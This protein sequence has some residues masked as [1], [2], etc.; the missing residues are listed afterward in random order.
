MS[1]KQ[2]ANYQTINTEQ[3]TVIDFFSIYTSQEYEKI[4]SLIDANYIDNSPAQAR[5][6]LEVVDILKAVSAIFPDLSYSILDIFSDRDRV[7]TRIRFTGTHSHTYIDAPASGNVITWEALENFSVENG[8]IVESW[9]YWPDYDMLRQM[10]SA[11]E[12]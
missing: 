5:G 2:Q 7:A 12:K 11:D 1:Q 8:K 6:T 9:G 3:Q 4:P 10:K